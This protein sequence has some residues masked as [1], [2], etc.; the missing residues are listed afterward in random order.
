MAGVVTDNE[1]KLVSMKQNLVETDPEL[2]VYGCSAYW[3]NL[4]G[5]DVTPSQMIRQVIEVNKNFRNHHV[6]GALLAEIQESVMPQLPTETRWNS[7]LCPGHTFT[8]HLAGSTT[9]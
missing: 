4:L 2:T 8:D 6:P 5:Q 1:N 7:Q 9:D 3:L